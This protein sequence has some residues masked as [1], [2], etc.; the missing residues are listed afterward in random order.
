MAELSTVTTKRHIISLQSTFDA[1]K[2]YYCAQKQNKKD[3]V[4]ELSCR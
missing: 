3:I 2:D 1:D 4:E